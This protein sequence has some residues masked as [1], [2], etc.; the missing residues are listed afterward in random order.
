[1]SKNVQLFTTVRNLSTH[2]CCPSAWKS[3]LVCSPTA[4]ASVVN[5]TC[6][7]RSCPAGLEPTSYCI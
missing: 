7:W 3:T 2:H 5:L 6:K 1:M 4:Q